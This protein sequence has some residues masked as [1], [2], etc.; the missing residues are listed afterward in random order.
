MI[1]FDDLDC[2]ITLVI[3]YIFV[4][5]LQGPPALR[6]RGTLTN[7]RGRPYDNNKPEA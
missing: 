1:G 7:L 6:E 3:S 4:G 2:K 5:Q